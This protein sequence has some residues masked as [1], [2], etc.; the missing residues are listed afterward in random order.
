MYILKDY[1]PSSQL[2]TIK[3]IFTEFV[4]IET[5]TQGT[6][7]NQRT[8]YLSCLSENKIKKAIKILISSFNFEDVLDDL[9]F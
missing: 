8:H 3:L 7:D 6:T 1:L 2:F 5:S 4:E 9:R